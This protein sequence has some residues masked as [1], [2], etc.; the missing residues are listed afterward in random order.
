MEE[1][2]Q[3]KVSIIEFDMDNINSQFINGLSNMDDLSGN[4]CG[5]GCYGIFCTV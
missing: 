4:W 2:K 3:S 5:N 1:K